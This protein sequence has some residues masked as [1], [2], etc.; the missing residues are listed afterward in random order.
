MPLLEDRLQ[1]IW[2][3]QNKQQQQF[4]LDPRTMSVLAKA[5]ASKDLA[6]GLYE[7]VKELVDDTTH[8]KAHVLR[9]PKVERTNVADEAADVFKYL[10]AICQLHGVTAQDLYDAFKRKTAVVSSKAHGQRVELERDTKLVI[11]DLD[12]CVADLSAWQNELN[13]Q[14]GDAPMND[15]TVKMLE[16]L[17][18][19]YYKGGGF[20]KL[21]A[22]VG[23]REALGAMREAGYK[24]AVIT[25][26]PSWQYKRIYADTIDWLA[27]HDIPY[28]LLLFGKDKAEEVYEHIYPARPLFFVEDRAK[29]CIEIANIGVKVLHLRGNTNDLAPHPLIQPMTDWDSIYQ[30]FKR[31][32]ADER[33]KHERD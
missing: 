22:V 19:E 5:T 11:T 28:D 6:L 31:M 33:Q 12:G 20:L 18:E 21:P 27:R 32:V 13:A 25:A 9:L 26:R 10:V 24:I 30:E 23:A 16:S 8:Y 15:G 17:K 29:H 4:N 14:R 1:E 2:D 7:E 3:I